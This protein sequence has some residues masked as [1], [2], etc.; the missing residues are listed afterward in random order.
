MR[1]ADSLLTRAVPVGGGAVGG[2]TGDTSVL[3]LLNWFLEGISIRNEIR[4]S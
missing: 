4:R 3:V 2:D 1:R